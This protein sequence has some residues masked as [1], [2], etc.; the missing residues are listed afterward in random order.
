MDT[1]E[2]ASVDAWLDLQDPNTNAIVNDTGIPLAEIFS[3]LDMNAIEPAVVNASVIG[4]T[5]FLEK[6]EELKKIV[7]GKDVTEL[8]PTDYQKAL[9]EF[10]KNPLVGC[11]SVLDMARVASGYDP[12]GDIK[13]T[14]NINAFNDYLKRVLACPFFHLSYSENSSYQRREKNW[15]TAINEIT[16]LFEGIEEDNKKTVRNSITSLAKAVA[17]NK[18][19]KQSKNLFTV[20]SIYA[21]DNRNFIETYMYSSSIQM[22]EHSKKGSDSKQTD[23]VIRKINL[24][25]N[26]SIWNSYAEK[27]LKKH[28]KLVDDW[29]DDNSTKPGTEKTNLCFEQER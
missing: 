21:P 3:I 22:E 9:D 24:T 4:S 17:S 8:S 11:T 19:T 25:F 6:E 13:S 14:K 26:S 28:I 23:L 2:M 1:N 12:N 15:D 10:R 5:G 18:N 29:L 16:N 20:S 27:V 7:K